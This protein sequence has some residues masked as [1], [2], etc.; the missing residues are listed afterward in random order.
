MASSYLGP[1]RFEVIVDREKFEKELN[2]AM[3]KAINAVEAPPKPKHVRSVLIATW[4]EKGC[5]SFWKVL[6][7]YPILRSHV[8]CWK[9]CFVI[10]R[11]FRDGYPEVVKKSVGQMR[12]LADVGKHWS[13]A[14]AGYA[15]LITAY[16]KVLMTRISF[17]IKVIT[18]TIPMTL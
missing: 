7:Q 8:Q 18:G 2:E 1:R 5:I 10:H 6:R 9:A 12:F 11:A 3:Q 13:H 15:P 17:I 4:R 16:I 14:V